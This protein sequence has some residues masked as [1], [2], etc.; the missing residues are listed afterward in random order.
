[1]EFRS[2]YLCFLFKRTNYM[3]EKYEFLF[4]YNFQIRIYKSQFL[5][6]TM[7]IK[8]NFPNVVFINLVFLFQN[9]NDEK[10]VTTMY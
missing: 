10:A 5:I 6:I 4:S 1:M 2:L 3:I 9:T 8:I 7:Y